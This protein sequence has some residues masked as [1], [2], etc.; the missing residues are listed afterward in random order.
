MLEFFV[1]ESEIMRESNI[2]PREEKVAKVGHF[3]DS[4][5]LI[6][7]FE[8]SYQSSCENARFRQKNRQNTTS[9]K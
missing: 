3:F 6:F 4:R 9:D 5:D 2:I 8:N 1:E 7:L